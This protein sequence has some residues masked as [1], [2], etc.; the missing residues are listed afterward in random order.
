MPDPERP[1]A[2]PRLLGRLRHAALA[3]LAPLVGGVVTA[4]PSLQHGPFEIVMHTRRIGAGG[5]GNLSA[6]PFRTTAVSSFEVRVGGRRVE[7]PGRSGTY[8]HVLRIDGAPQPALLATD[9]PMHLITVAQ[10][11]PQVQT[12][13]GDMAT[14]Q[15]LDARNG[16]PGPVQ[17]FG[18][19]P[20]S[21]EDTWLRGG[22][23][24]LIDRRV[25]LDVSTLTARPVEPWVIGG[26]NAS[27][28]AAVAL[29]PRATL[30]AM[31]AT[32]PSGERRDA[33]GVLVI[34]LVHGGTHAVPLGPQV[35][36]RDP[37]EP[38]QDWFARHYA[39]AADAEG[40]ERLAVRDPPWPWR[41]R[42]V[43]VAF[44]EQR[45][46]HV[47]R[48]EPE[49]GLALA[50][51]LQ[52]RWAA[53]PQPDVDPRGAGHY[54]VPGCGH[55]LRLQVKGDGLLLLAPTASEPPWHRCQAELLRIAEAFDAELASGRH[56]RLLRP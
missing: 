5:F 15:W 4:A 16:Q 36:P 27:T 32:G 25:V 33:H 22:R 39:W 52:Q 14:L 41:R 18:A 45:E 9:G 30:Y 47:R 56:D 38:P 46:Y 55:R 12:F 49:L 37:G 51:L 48:V 2:T 53:Q 44:G 3:L 7:L 11:R 1:R 40:R 31:P 34:D 6:N 10:G 26:L 13:G 19:M 50:A 29:S 24:L 17:Q 42:G 23:W 28:E 20:L 35:P 8:W 21:I 43:L 54:V